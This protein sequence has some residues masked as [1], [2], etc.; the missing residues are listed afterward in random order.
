MSRI[1]L[2]VGLALIV[3]CGRIEREI[4]ITSNPPGALVWA[5]DQEIGRT[6]FTRDFT[7]YGTYDVILRKDG[8]QTLHTR[9]KVIAPWW[10]WPP[11]D[12][13]AEIVPWHWLDRRHFAYDLRPAST[14]PAD[15]EMMLSRAEQLRI[16][17]QGSRFTRNP[18]TIPVTK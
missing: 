15:P 9:T 5:N 13:V 18:A 6:P 10:Q 11:I 7:W 2:L 4:S 1:C 8:Y 3:G 17:L 12:L 14:Q 16:R